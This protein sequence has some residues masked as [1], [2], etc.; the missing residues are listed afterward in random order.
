[1]SEWSHKNHVLCRICDV[2][3]VQKQIENVPDGRSSTLTEVR[4][5][6]RPLHR[7]Q[8][9]PRQQVECHLQP[10]RH[11]TLELDGKVSLVPE[12]RS[13]IHPSISQL[14]RRPWQ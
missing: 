5:R 11:R 8:V 13:A 7:Q 2:R 10:L 1:M 6:R 3:F 14:C 12:C 9:V 4:Y